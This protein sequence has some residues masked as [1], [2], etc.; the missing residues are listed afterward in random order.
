MGETILG[1]ANPIALSLFFVFILTTLL[2]LRFST[3]SF[4]K[5]AQNSA[6]HTSTSLAATVGFT[7][8]SPF[9]WADTFKNASP[10]FPLSNPASIF[11]SRFYLAGIVGSLVRP[12]EKVKER[13][14]ETR[15]KSYAGVSAG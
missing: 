11:I 8:P 3:A 14:K 1:H 12:E 2:V 5:P 15:L 9:V 6:R 13:F 7:S 10:T 4:T